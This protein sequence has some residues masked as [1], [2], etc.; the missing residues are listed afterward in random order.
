M[1]N[2]SNERIPEFSF[3][4]GAQSLPRAWVIINCRT[5]PS[6]LYAPKLRVSIWRELVGIESAATFRADRLKITSLTF[7]ICLSNH[8]SDLNL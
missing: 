3:I 8:P 7:D 2:T 1:C 5:V 6:C 4:D